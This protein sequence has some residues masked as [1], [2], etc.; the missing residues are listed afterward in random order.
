MK[1]VIP[2]FL[3]L[4]AC[5]RPD[6]CDCQPLEPMI[7][8]RTGFTATWN[9][10][11]DDPC[12]E[13]FIEKALCSPLSLDTSVQI[14]LFNNPILQQWYENVGISQAD[15]FQ[16]GLFTNPFGAIDFRIAN[17]AGALNTEFNFYQS[18]LDLFLVPLREKVQ[19]AKLQQTLFEVSSQILTL[20]FDIQRTYY[21]LSGLYQNLEIL[22]SMIE[23][24][25]GAV[26][27]ANAQLAAGNVDPIESVPKKLVLDQYLVEKN[28][29]LNQ[30]VDLSEH[31]NELLGFQ[32]TDFCWCIESELP[33]LPFCLP[34]LPCLEELALEKR[35]DLQALKWQV[36]YIKRQYPT[37]EWWAKT[38]T[39]VGVSS[40][41]DVDGTFTIGPSIVMAL[42]IFNYGQ[43]DKARITSLYKQAI[44]QLDATE[45][46]VVTNI[47]RAKN[48][49]HTYFE[50]AR[51]YKYDILEHHEA[52]FEEVLAHYLYMV[53]DI[54]T[55]LEDKQLQFT[56]QK[57]YTDLLT[58]FWIS[59]VDL[60]EAVGGVL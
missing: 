4:T 1:K 55:L 23:I 39:F 52:V 58:Q 29:L 17:K 31:F 2:L 12:I 46:Q 13:E 57:A 48:A 38:D 11:Q 54:Y 15:L 21:S 28:A 56:Y 50:N 49:V 7:E 36:E 32:D 3:L 33:P 5:Q 47:G 14:A 35:Y 51:K 24:Q 41:N 10:C 60:N 37:V 26:E 45:V 44:W 53:G 27:I 40:E 6:M 18:L 9:H 25:E 43:A 16:A 20:I 42:P 8:C 59:T 19:E 30:I 34:P 22:N